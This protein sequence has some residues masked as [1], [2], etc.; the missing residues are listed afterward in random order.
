[1]TTRLSTVLQTRRPD[2]HNTKQKGQNH[3]NQRL[4]LDSKLPLH[5]HSTTSVASLRWPGNFGPKQVVILTEI[6]T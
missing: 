4:R 5:D 6:R 3:H 1:M 2:R